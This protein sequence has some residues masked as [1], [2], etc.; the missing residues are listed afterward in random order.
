MLVKLVRHHGRQQ[1]AADAQVGVGAALFRDQRIGRLLDPVV[2]KSVG[3][4]LPQNEACV[5]RLPQPRVQRILCLLVNQSERGDIGD[6]PKAGELFHRLL[7]GGGEPLHLFDHEIGNVL[8]V[9][10]GADAIDVP[11]PG[12][13]DR[14]EHEETLSTK[15]S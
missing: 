5:D 6:V 8:G 9:A 4:L 11:S 7:R 3:A 15:Y 10:P 2:K 1:H 13:P 14:V 12:W